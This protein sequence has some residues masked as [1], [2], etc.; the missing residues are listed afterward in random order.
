MHFSKL[1]VIGTTLATLAGCAS[2]TPITVNTVPTNFQIAQPADPAPLKLSKIKFSVV[3][4]ATMQTFIAA[5]IKAQG[6]PNPVFIV[7]DT[8]GYKAIRLNLAELQRY[9]QDQKQIIVYYKNTT[10][11][12]SNP[13]AFAKR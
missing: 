7:L 11:Y 1:L 13:T 2:V 6:N 8:N 3:T 12:I 4:Q 5:Q 10:S 9:I